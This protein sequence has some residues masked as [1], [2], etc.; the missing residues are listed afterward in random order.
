MQMIIFGPDVLV[1]YL[2]SQ[3]YFLIDHHCKLQ[4]EYLDTVKKCQDS[5][6]F[7]Q[8]DVEN[9]TNCHTGCHESDIWCTGNQTC[10]NGVFPKWIQIFTEFSKFRETDKIT[11][12]WMR[13]NLMILS[14]TCAFVALWYHLCLL[15]K[16]PGFNS[17]I[18]FIFEKK[19]SLN[20]VKTFRENSNAPT[21]RIYV[22]QQLSKTKL[23]NRCT[24]HVHWDTKIT[25]SESIHQTWYLT[26]NMTATLILFYICLKTNILTFRCN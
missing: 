18:L 14:F 12:A 26:L 17:A 11:E 4:S 6:M 3:V 25:L 1:I 23:K 16:G 20:S 21:K 22:C 19:L 5:L 24:I 15:S 2:C 13:V 10:I 7:L 8:G 9:V